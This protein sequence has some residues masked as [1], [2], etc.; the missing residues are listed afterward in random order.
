MPLEELLNQEV[1]L[2]TGRPEP[3]I[4]SPSAV[5][6]I[7]SEESRRS[8]AMSLPEALR[9]A[10]NL[11][12]AQQNAHDWAITAR[13]F[14]GAPLANNSLADKLLVM[15]D[16]RSVYSPLFGGVFWDVQNVLLEDIDRIEVVSGPGAT[17]WGA[18]A[19]NGVIN[20]VTKSSR[21]TQG[22]YVSGAAGSYWQDFGAVRYG[23]GNGSNLFY[24]V[25]GQRFDH[26]G[27]VRAN[28][29]DAMDPWD[30]TQ[31]GFRMDYVPSGAH[32]FTFQGDFY[33]GS[34]GIPTATIVDG[35]NVLGRWIRTFSPTS[36]LTV[37]A[38]WDR[39]WRRLPG[40]GF[41]ED[42]NTFD[43]DAQH[44]FGVGDR[45]TVVWGG[46]YRLMHESVE[47]TPVF[48]FLPAERNLQLFSAF[49]QDEI[50][51]WPDRLKLTLGTKIEHNDFSGFEI[52]PNGR[53]AWT[54]SPT[55]TVW[56]A[57]SRAVRSPARF[58]ADERTPFIAT[59]NHDF[60]P[61]K[62]PGLR[63]RIPRPPGEAPL[64]FTGHF[65]QPLR[66]SPEHRSERFAST[67]PCFFE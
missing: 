41:A 10:S 45:Q 22:L 51:L 29:T 64:A 28:G 24:R 1:S 30:M 7:T 32:T 34:E 55:H 47:N 19:V 57:V 35:E 61:E 5:Q 13:G 21:A 66:R 43:L 17:L 67:F 16:G 12:V 36:A 25:Y 2:V 11:Q 53:L 20:V 50:S 18:N 63:T 58:D 40:A 27:S 46:D 3:L 14:N 9:L 54:P 31:G 39:T 23:G 60:K 4:Q 8:G 65:L 15:I 59:P 62:V 44:R 56:A 6:V 48:S 37:R 42:L 26:N 38:Y 33:S 52:Q 49:L